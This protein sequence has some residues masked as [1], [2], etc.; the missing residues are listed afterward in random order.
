MTM[1]QFN[2]Y[3][4]GLSAEHPEWHYS[5]DIRNS[6][7]AV[8]VSIE[9]ADDFEL[10]VISMETFMEEYGGKLELTV[11]YVHSSRGERLSIEENK[12]ID[13]IVE[14]LKNDSHY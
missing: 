12:I 3:L 8:I 6:D 11:N 9:N 4:A 2:E 10:A 7:H 5:L 1:N 14:S 13:S